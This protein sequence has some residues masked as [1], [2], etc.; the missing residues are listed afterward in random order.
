[1][2]EGK[3]LRFWSSADSGNASRAGA[4][5]V[6][7]DGDLGLF[8]VADGVGSHEASAE[9]SG[10]AVQTFRQV[11]LAETAVIDGVKNGLSPRAR[12]D[13]LRL[14][15]KALQQACAAVFARAEAEPSKRGAGTTLDALLVV[16]SRGYLA[17]VGNSRVYLVREG[18]VHQLTED[19]LLINELLKR[20]RL[21]QR[22][23]EKLE[24]KNVVTRAVG[25]HQSVE[26][27]T[28]DLDL[29]PGDRLLMCT[30]AL[31]GHLEPSDIRKTFEEGPSDQVAQLFINAV[32]QRG[33]ADHVSAIVLEAPEEAGPD[34]LAREV[35]LK[36]EV[37]HKMPVFRYLTY[38]EL[39][40]VMGFTES[41]CFG[42][43]EVIVKEGDDGEE[44]YIVLS[45]E[46]RVHSGDNEIVVLGAGQHF[47]EMALIDRAPRSASVT[48]ILESKLIVLRRKQFFDIVREDHDVAVKLLWSFL[49]VLAKRLR[50]TSKELGDARGR[51]SMEEVDPLV[52][53][54]VQD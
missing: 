6:L 33:G 7:V 3:A 29:L 22:Q 41:K 13:L 11:L 47:G 23:A 36:L 2:S 39:V 48:S 16:G 54:A 52:S 30:D 40:R 21:T 12:E 53:E 8:L 37:L 25:F 49:G 31:S 26:A 17:H 42:P 10:L 1:M 32:R 35:N 50:S 24:Y 18:S 19:H 9:A 5:S 43:D 4:D 44:L 45:G 15:E 28:F 51:L 46:V 38:Q 14:M 20:G 34:P 27:D